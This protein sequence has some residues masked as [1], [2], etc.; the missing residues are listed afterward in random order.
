[1]KLNQILSIFCQTARYCEGPKRTQLTMTTT[2]RKPQVWE[3]D[4][5]IICLINN[6]KIKQ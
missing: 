3:A 5:A 6:L 4:T 1:M 2:Q